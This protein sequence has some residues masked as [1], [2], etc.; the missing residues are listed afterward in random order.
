MTL[1]V[2]YTFVQRVL[3]NFKVAQEHCAGSMRD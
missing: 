2:M 3:G 1:Q